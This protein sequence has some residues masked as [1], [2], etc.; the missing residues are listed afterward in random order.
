MCPVSVYGNSLDGT[1]I[2]GFPPFFGKVN[3][4]IEDLAVI[5]NGATETTEQEHNFN[6]RVQFFLHDV[7]ADTAEVNAAVAC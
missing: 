3:S 2:N 1:N 6:T 7:H 4:V 5:W